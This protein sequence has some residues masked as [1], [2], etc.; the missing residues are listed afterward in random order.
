M[1][2]YLLSVYQPEGTPPSPD[3]LEKIMRDL[4]SRK[5]D[6]GPL[7][8]FSGGLNSPAPPP[9]CGSMAETCS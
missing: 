7:R 5:R 8:Q 2:Q 4:M 1:K 9:C 3:V 6:E